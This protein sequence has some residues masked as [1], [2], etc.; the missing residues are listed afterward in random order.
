MPADNGPMVSAKVTGLSPALPPSSP[1]PDGPA[2]PQSAGKASA[3][4]RPFVTVLGEG[5]PAGPPATP[6]TS[7]PM[8]T[9]AIAPANPS[10]ATPV[11]T[12]MQG[13]FTAERELDALMA[14]AGR[15]K[16]FS[17]AELLVLQTKVF[18]YSQ[19]VEVIS[20]ATDKLVG[21]IKQALGT[22]V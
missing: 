9:A 16:T 15:G 20:R 2:A 21:G 12:L 4:T 22:Q 10:A 18:R 8:A 17:P 3:G 14:A 5:A 7:R 6:A 1:R 19:T 13:A 11:R